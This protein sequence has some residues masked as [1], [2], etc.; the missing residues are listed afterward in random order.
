M[1]RP[2]RCACT[3]LECHRLRADP[4]GRWVV[5]K[6][7]DWRISLQVKQSVSDSHHPPDFLVPVPVQIACQREVMSKRSQDHQDPMSSRSNVQPYIISTFRTAERIF[8]SRCFMQV[9]TLPPNGHAFFMMDLP[10]QDH[11][12]D[13]VDHLPQFVLPWHTFSCSIK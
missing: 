5:R 10:S 7:W 11:P 6:F 12:E 4:G 2:T 3:W 1:W 8:L 9:V 13:H